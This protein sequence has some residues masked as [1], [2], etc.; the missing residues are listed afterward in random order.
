M[1]SEQLKKSYKTD[2]LGIGTNEEDGESKEEV[3]EQWKKIQKLMSSR[4]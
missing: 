4:W 3:A 2:H 1:I